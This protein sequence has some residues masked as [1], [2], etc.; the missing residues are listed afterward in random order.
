MIGA[1]QFSLMKDL[2]IL[3]NTSRGAVVDQDEL[4]KALESGKVWRA[5][6]D[7]F[8]GEPRINDYF[9][10]SE[11]VITQPHTGGLTRVSFKRAERERF[12]DVRAFFETG[13]PL[14]PGNELAEKKA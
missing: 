14:A 10:K 7:V 5:G 11:K 12:E 2:S 3:I 1:S 13:R 4:I 8:C 9:M 6:L